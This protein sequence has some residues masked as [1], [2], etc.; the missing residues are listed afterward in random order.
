[1]SAAQAILFVV[2]VHS[3]PVCAAGGLLLL[4]LLL[5]VALHLL[6]PQV[7]SVV[8]VAVADADS[9][10]TSLVSSPANTSRQ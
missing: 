8:V 4:L 9:A 10:H 2:G 5:Q 6:S 1:L 7:A 3:E